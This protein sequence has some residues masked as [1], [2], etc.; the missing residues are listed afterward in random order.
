MNMAPAPIGAPPSVLA[1]GRLDR[2]EF[3]EVKSLLTRTAS[4]HAVGGLREAAEYLE[5]AATPPELIILA[6]APPGQFPCSEVGRLRPLAPLARFWGLLGVLCEGEARSGK[7]WP[8]VPRCYWHQ[9]APRWNREIAAIQ[10]RRQPSWLLPETASDDERLLAMMDVPAT[11]GSG[12]I[13]IHAVHEM[14]DCLTQACRRRGYS[15]VAIWPG[16]HPCCVIEGAR[17]ILWDLHEHQ[18]HGPY[19]RPQLSPANQELPVIALLG[20]P[21]MEDFRRATGQGIVLVAKPFLVD[22]LMWHLERTIS[23]SR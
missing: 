3:K 17:A 6:Q 21:R 23:P 5:R 11:S 2:E 4:L 1:I 19:L 8:G 13:V 16:S 22:D 12:L 20:F 7:P 9:F 15:T 18:L 14:A 10:A